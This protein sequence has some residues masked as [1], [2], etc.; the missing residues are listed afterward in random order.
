MTPEQEDKLLVDVAVIVE[1]VSSIEKEITPQVKKN[2]RFRFMITGFV[3]ISLPLFG[4]VLKV[5]AK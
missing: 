1:K 3:I 5:M 4:V 2:T